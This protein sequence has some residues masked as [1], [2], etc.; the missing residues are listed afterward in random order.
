MRRLAKT[1]GLIAVV[2]ML[3]TGCRSTGDAEATT[4]EEREQAVYPR[5]EEAASQTLLDVEHTLERGSR[6]EDA[7]TPRATVVADVLH[8]TSRRSAN[9]YLAD[10]GWT[11]ERDTITLVSPDG[12]Y[13]AHPTLATEPSVPRHVA[14]Y[15]NLNTTT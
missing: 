5:L 14:L 2:G 8:W 12:R 15:F 9:E 6:C 10:M 1:L 13:T 11:R 3:A 4:C 7:G